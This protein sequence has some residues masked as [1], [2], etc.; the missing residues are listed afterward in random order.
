[1]WDWYQGIDNEKGNLTVLKENL[2]VTQR[3]V[4]PRPDRIDFYFG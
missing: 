4:R 3:E 1:M 2:I